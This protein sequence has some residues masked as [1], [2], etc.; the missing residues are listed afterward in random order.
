MNLFSPI[1]D[2]MTT[3]LVTVNPGDKL[4]HVKELFE[5]QG[6]HHVPV[7]RFKTMVGI[8]SKSDLLL[9]E[10]GFSKDG[11]EDLVEK[12]RLGSYRA[13][14]IMTTGMAK[15]EPTDRINVA[16]EVFKENLFHAIPIVSNE[17][18]VGLLTTYDIIRALA[19]GTLQTTR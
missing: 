13:E 15:L 2:I 14:D 19:D 8:I 10:R 18:L 17:E 4:S 9:F 6:I 5:L 16:L 7:V 1:S 3:D 11:Y 12:S